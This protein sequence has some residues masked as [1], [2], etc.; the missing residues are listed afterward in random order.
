M[1]K[2]TL[3]RV[4]E[5]EEYKEESNQ[6]SEEESDSDDTPQTIRTQQSIKVVTAKVMTNVQI[7]KED[8]QMVKLRF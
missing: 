2:L 4:E 8:L 3:F 7:F 5:D 1:E 6:S